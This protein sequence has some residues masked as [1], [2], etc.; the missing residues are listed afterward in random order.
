MPRINR[1]DV[2]FPGPDGSAWMARFVHE[3]AAHDAVGGF[4]WFNED[5]KSIQIKHLT[6]CKLSYRD[7]PA[8][9]MR[10]SAPCSLRDTYDW[11]KGLR[12]AF[13]RSLSKGG[14]CRE[15]TERGGELHNGTIYRKGQFVSLKPTFGEIV[16]SFYREL[17]IKDYWPHREGDDPQKRPLPNVIEGVVV[18]DPTRLLE[19]GPATGPI[20]P[21]NQH[22]ISRFPWLRPIGAVPAINQHGLGY[23]G[24]D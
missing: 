1:T 15:V 24:A 23:S 17:P 11:K 14:Y 5:L 22:P 3:H 16:S 10:G 6:T 9:Y 7:Q 18:T 19:A 4:V 2:V 20:P 8:V 13:L 21:Y 12:L